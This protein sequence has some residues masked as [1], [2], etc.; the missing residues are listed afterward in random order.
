LRIAKVRLRNRLDQVIAHE[1][2]EAAGISHEEA[3]QRA[4]EAPLAIRETAKERLR[5]MAEAENRGKRLK[6]S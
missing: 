5:A 3:I 4:A 2:A 6:N 1:H